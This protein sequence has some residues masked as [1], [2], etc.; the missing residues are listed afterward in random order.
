MDDNLIASTGAAYLTDTKKKRLQL[1]AIFFLQEAKL[2]RKSIEFIVE[3]CAR[4]HQVRPKFKVGFCLATGIAIARRRRQL[5]HVSEI[6]G[7]TDRHSTF[8]YF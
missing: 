3:E 2:R 5:S 4:H 7:R 1:A 6:F 8:I